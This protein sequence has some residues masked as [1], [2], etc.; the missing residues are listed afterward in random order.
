MSSDLADL[1]RA[2]VR[3]LAARSAELLEASGW[4]AAVLHSGRAT[5]RSRFDDQDWPLRPVPHF[6]HWAPLAWP[7]AFVCLRLGAA[8]RLVVVRES[9]FWEARPEPDWALLA[10]GMELEVL[11]GAEGLAERLAPGPR[12]VFVG[13]A[14]DAAAGWGFTPEQRAP[15]SLLA[16]LEALRVHKSAYEIACMTEASRVAARGHRAAE[17]AFRAGERR[18]LAL[19]LRYLEATGQDAFDTPYQ[20]IVALDR[21]AAVLHHV[22]YAREPRL[23]PSAAL[24]VDAGAQVRGYHADITRTHVV[25][26]E[27]DA[28]AF[29]ALVDGLDAVQRALCD[30]V[31]AGRPYEALHDESHHRIAT[32][33]ESLG[34]LRRPEDAVARGVTRKF[35]PHGLGHS[36]GVQT[37]DVGCR[38]RPPRPDNPFLRNTRDIEAGMAFTIEPG[39]YFIDALLEP[40]RSAPEGELVCWA[41]VDRLHRFGGVR[42]EDDVVVR[43]PEDGGLLNLTREAFEAL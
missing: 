14:V 39:V 8:P 21:H 31:R 1:Y 2:H 5:P 20:N 19:H 30:A 27:P 36:L 24:L 23:G 42:I 3:A 13:E 22:D 6:Q 11:D 35:F 9:S 40:L 18:E 10:A 43:A 32:L 33:M 17:A 25:G 38:L 28:A 4:D 12:T 29:A 7:D 37:H 26:Q 34:L 15:A 41:E 16:G